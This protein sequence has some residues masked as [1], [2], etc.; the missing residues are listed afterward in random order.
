MQRIVL[1]P[2]ARA[3]GAVQ[4]NSALRRHSFTAGA[5]VPL[6][7]SY[8]P[9]PF[10]L[11]QLTGQG[12][13]AQ[14]ASSSAHLPQRTVGPDLDL[15]PGPPAARTARVRDLLQRTPSTPDTAHQAA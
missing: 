1:L 11:S 13:D 10:G 14:N 9:T 5:T 15:E 2:A 8:F 12:R 7:A 4:T 3:P 6:P